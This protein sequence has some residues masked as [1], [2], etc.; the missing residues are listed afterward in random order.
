MHHSQ[1]APLDNA[2]EAGDAPGVSCSAPKKFRARKLFLT[3]PQCEDSKEDLYD[4]LLKTLENKGITQMV[5]AQETH[6]D[7]G[8]H[9]HAYVSI[10]KD[11]IA[12]GA[13][14]SLVFNGKNPNV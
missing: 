9:L 12:R 13:H 8:H 3:Y 10:E 14:T 5:I 11:Y 7:G 4:F 6:Q 1:S 2:P